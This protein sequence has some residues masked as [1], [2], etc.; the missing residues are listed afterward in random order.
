MLA[1]ALLFVAGFSLVFIVGWGGAATLAGRLFSQY[2]TSLG[3][4]GGLLVILFGLH[5]LG[6]VRIPF[7]NMDTRPQAG[8]KARGQWLNS[9]LMGIFFAAGWTPCVGIT[10]G[11]IL[12]LGFSQESSGQAML[13]SAS[14]ALGL[15][16]PF[17]I[18]AVLLDRAL[19]IVRRMGK[20]M[21][22][23]QR[24][25]GVLL[26]VIG[27]LMISDRMTYIAI[28]AQRNGFYLDIPLGGASAP[29]ILAAGALSFFSPCVLPL[30]PAYLGYLG[31]QGL[32]S[33][34]ATTG[35]KA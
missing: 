18:L 7:L 21:L 10:L 4:I 11:A 17:L 26:I 25:S 19:G 9:G 28:W 35:K 5:T 32:N 8:L 34:A 33:R 22:L 6:V 1:H 2:K 29:T 15:G 14:Y 30:V 12:T 23:F 31:G 13:L 16:I 20:Y 24:I 27:V 3:R